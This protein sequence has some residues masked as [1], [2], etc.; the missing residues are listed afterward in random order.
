MPLIKKILCATDLSGFS[1]DLLSAC[2]ALCLR[3]DASLIVFHA[4]PPPHGSVARQIEFERGGERRE[5]ISIAQKQIKKT[6]AHLDIKWESIVTYGDPVLEAAKAAEEANPDMVVAASHGLSVFQQF[7]LGSVIGRM[8]QT[9]LRPLL[10]LPPGNTVFD[11]TCPKLK[12]AH[13]VIACGLTPS[14]A[15]LKKYAAAFSEGFNWKLHLVHVMES[16]V[17]E[18]LMAVPFGRYDETQRLLEDKIKTNLNRL[19]PGEAIILH[20]VPGEALAD[21]ASPHGI[22]LIIAGGDARPDGIIPT[23]SATL[24]RHLPCAVL[25]IPVKP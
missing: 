16:P 9:I 15:R 11:T 19:M 7:F 10:V 1:D 17:N 8:A 14:D 12:S 13:I 2:I 4:V 25:I 23:T 20:G 6:M 21:Y 24:L 18:K 5:K 3:F 22:A